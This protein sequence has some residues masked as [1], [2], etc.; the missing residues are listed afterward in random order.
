MKQTRSTRQK[1]LIENKLRR[2]KNLFTVEDLHSEIKK[3]DSKIGIA[4]IY[5]F[6]KETATKKRIHSYECNRRKIYSFESNNHCHFICE[7]CGKIEH[8]N[9]SKLDFL[10]TSVKGDICHFQINVYGLCEKCK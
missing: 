1:E 3:E 5:R 9:V 8:F 6:M 4:T 7:K 10:K 2:M